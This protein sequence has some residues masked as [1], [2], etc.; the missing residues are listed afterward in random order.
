M[1]TAP[2]SDQERAKILKQMQGFGGSLQGLP[3]LPKLNDTLVLP[4]PEEKGKK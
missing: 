1:E 2:V 3:H 4:E